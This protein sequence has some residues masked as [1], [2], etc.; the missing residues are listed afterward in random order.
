[1]PRK[2]G[3]PRKKAIPDLEPPALVEVPGRPS[4]V[5]DYS[6]DTASRYSHASSLETLNDQNLAIDVAP[7]P[8]KAN[9]SDIQLSEETKDVVLNK[10]RTKL[11][12]ALMSWAWI[13]HAIIILGA[14]YVMS[15]WIPQGYTDE[16]IWNKGCYWKMGWL[17]PLPYTAICFAGLILPIHNAR[18]PPKDVAPRRVDNLYILTV[19][20]GDNKEA[21]MRAWN[22]HK[23]LE[24]LDPCIRVHVLTDE[25]NHFDNINCYTCPKSF[26]TARSKY[27]ARALEWYRTTMRYTEHDWV[28]HLDEESVIDDESVQRCLN[29]IRYEKDYSW[30]QGIIL[31]NQYKFWRNPFFTVADGLRVGDDLARFHLQYTYLRRPVF[32]AHGS[33]LLTN[34]AV[35][36]AVTWDLGSLTEDFQ[37]AVSAWKLGFKCGNIS[38]IV[39]EQSPL[40]LIGFLKQRR[41]WFVGIRRLPSFL[42]KVL[43]LFWALGLVS[44]YC[45]IASIVLGFYVPT[46]TPRW[47]GILKD[48]SFIVF[49]YLYVL[50][51]FVQNVDKGYNPI[52]VIIGIP[53]TVAFQ[54]VAVIMEAVAVMYGIIFPPADFDVIKK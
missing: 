18:P 35:E 4:N 19:T 11:V 6:N 26:S 14:T 46:D 13:F 10:G 28:L 54:F 29:F 31:Y 12:M 9:I 2:P 20:K 23:H 25:P 51:M 48:F 15:F 5:S 30:G 22:A 38:G 8:K 1:M 40:D 44:L 42:P 27:K 7:T 45:T 17:L 21:V 47:F 49:I 41:R 37:F 24:K 53:V 43:A 52:L 50:G 36:N 32:G 33:F 3:S 16:E 39:R 34:G